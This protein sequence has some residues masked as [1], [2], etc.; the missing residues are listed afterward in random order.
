VV[1]VGGSLVTHGGQNLLEPAAQ[2][3]AILCGPHTANFARIAEDMAAIGALRRVG[4]V[5]E[6]TAGVEALLNDAT[7]R[8]PMGEAAAA[9]ATTQSEVLDRVFAALSKSLARAAG[10]SPRP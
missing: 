10:A 1:F 7:L 3:C 9:Y 4:D 2:G 8:A 6:L 5:A